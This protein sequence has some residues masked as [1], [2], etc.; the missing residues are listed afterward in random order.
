MRKCAFFQRSSRVPLAST[1][2]KAA[3]S[4]LAGVLV[5]LYQL[6]AKRQKLQTRDVLVH[7]G[8]REDVALNTDGPAQMSLQ[9]HMMV[10]FFHRFS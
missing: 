9:S 1:D 5:L 10:A 7:R 2:R 8:R 6:R 3:L 4:S